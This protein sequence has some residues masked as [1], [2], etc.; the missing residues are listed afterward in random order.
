MMFVLHRGVSL[1]L[2]LLC[3]YLLRSSLSVWAIVFHVSSAVLSDS[4]VRLIRQDG[5]NAI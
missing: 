1:A 4:S 2:F 3:P 5:A